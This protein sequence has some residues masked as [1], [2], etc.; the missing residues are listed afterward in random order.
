[1]TTVAASTFNYEL[2]GTAEFSD[3]T[4]YR[5]A[6]IMRNGVAASPVVLAVNAAAAGAVTPNLCGPNTLDPAKVA[7]KIVVCDRGDRYLSSDLFG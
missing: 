7:G 6:S 2:Q 1:M 5:G 4:K 3:G